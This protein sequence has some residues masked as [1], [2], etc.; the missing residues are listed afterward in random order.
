MQLK[1][2]RK[3][4]SWVAILLILQRS[5]VLPWVKNAALLIGSIVEKTW[6]WKIVMPAASA[7]GSWHSLSG[8]SSYVTSSQSNPTTVNE[9]DSFSFRFY[10]RGYRAGSSV[11]Y[12]HLTL[13]TMDSV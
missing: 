13:P 12:T 7:A 3:K 1:V 2:V 4:V 10:T 6:T 9:G 8:A 5:P 11:S